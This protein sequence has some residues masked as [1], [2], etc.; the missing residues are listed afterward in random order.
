MTVTMHAFCRP[1]RRIARAALSAA[2]ALAL[3]ALS[4]MVVKDQV[5]GSKVGETH[6]VSL[7]ANS[8]YGGEMAC[9]ASFCQ[10][11][12]RSDQTSCIMTLIL[13]SAFRN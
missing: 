1:G 5:H 13:G 10:S 6:V 4:Y 9:M 8:L 2:A 12:T 3:V 7:L 11:S